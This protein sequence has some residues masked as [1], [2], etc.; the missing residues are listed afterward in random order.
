MLRKW[1]S[2]V[3]AAGLLAASSTALA[4]GTQ[5]GALAPGRAAGVHKAQLYMYGGLWIWV[6]GGAIV[7]TG[8]AAVAAAGGNSNSAVTT[9]S[10]PA[11]SC[12][13]PSTPSTSST[14]ASSTTAT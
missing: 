3:V 11:S 7:A 9:T 5:Q 6:V 4:A 2:I 10:C 1:G 8:A 14:S 13:A 12:P